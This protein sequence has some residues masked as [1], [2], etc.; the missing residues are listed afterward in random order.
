[1]PVDKVT[2]D[3]AGRLHDPA[4][5]LREVRTRLEAVSAEEATNRARA[6]RAASRDGLSIACEAHG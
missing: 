5:H 1:M 2:R 3:W 6:S 4:G